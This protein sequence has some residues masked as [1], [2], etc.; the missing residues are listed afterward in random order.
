M[1]R[2]VGADRLEPILDWTTQQPINQIELDGF[3][4]LPDQILT[5]PNSLNL[6]S[7]AGAKAIQ[8]PNFGRQDDTAFGGK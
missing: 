7:L 8:F 5:I 6:E 2:R 1:R 4:D 3:D